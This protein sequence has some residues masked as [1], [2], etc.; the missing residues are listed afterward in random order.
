MFYSDVNLTHITSLKEDAIWTRKNPVTPKYP[1]KLASSDIAGCGI[2]KV[3]V[4]EQGETDSVEL[5]T[6]V[7]K[8]E[9]FKPSKKVI[10]NWEWA[11]SDDKLAK[12][13]EKTI[14]LDYCMGAKSQEAATKQCQKQAKLKCSI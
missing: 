11:K 5:I 12:A 13:E 9:I 2:F 7:P 3:I 10:K 14:R 1:M 6:S 8:K 4:N